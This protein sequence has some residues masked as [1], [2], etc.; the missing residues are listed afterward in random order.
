MSPVALPDGRVP[1]LLSAHAPELLATDATALLRYLTPDARV[2]DIASTLLRTRRIRRHR[3]VV[4]AADSAEL[5]DGLAAVAAGAT[6][7]LVTAAAQV[8]APRLAF[9][10]PGQGGQ[11]PGMGADA[12]HTMPAYRA[13]ADRCA[14]AFESL[15]VASPLPNLL[16]TTGVWS[17]L[18]LQGAQFTHAVALARVWASYGFVADLVLGH[19][20]GE[21]GAAYHAGAITLRTA[22]AVVA[23]R[24]STMELLPDSYAVA[25]LGVSPAEADGL[26]ASVAGWAELSVVNSAS[27]V[28]VSGDRDTV[29]ALVERVA[30]RG[31]FARRLTATSPFHTSVFEPLRDEFVSRLP[32]DE[33][34]EPAVRFVGSATAAG[35]ST[36]TDFAGYWYANLR[37]TVRFDRAA[38]SAIDAGARIFVEMS[39]HPAVHFA[40]NAV[41]DEVLPD[42]AVLTVGSGRRDEPTDDVLSEAVTAVAAADPQFRW[43]ELVDEDRRP[44]RNFPNAPMSAIH[45]WPAPKPLPAAQPELTVATERWVEMA[46]PRRAED[47]RVALLTLGARDDLAD[48]IT[49]CTALSEPELAD[50]LVVVAP[51]VDDD[52][53]R[54][55]AAAIGDGVLDYV[56]AIGTRCRHV[57]L[58]TTGGEQVLSTDPLASPGQAALAA[59]H[60]CLAFEHPDQTFGHLDLPVGD[61][62]TAAATLMLDAFASGTTEVALRGARL[63][64]RE[65][66]GKAAIATPWPTGVLDDVLITGG[67]GVIGMNYARALAERGARRIVL[68]SRRGADPAAV[69]QLRTYG[70]E[71]LSVRCDITDAAQVLSA[72]AE[73]GSGGASLVIHAAGVAGF[74]TRTS[75][76]A[77]HVAQMAA[78]KIGGLATLV[79]C[80]PM[81]D[82]TRIL[83]CSSVSGLWG[84]KGMI[85]Y[86]AANRMLDVM[87]AHLRACGRRCTA[88]RW[89]LWSG[90]SLLGREGTELVERSGLRGMAPASAIGASLGD[91]GIDPLILSADPDRLRIF[92]GAMEPTAAPVTVAGDADPAAAVRGHLA[93][94]L[95]TDPATLDLTMSLFDLGVDSLLAIDLR[96]RLKRTTGQSVPLARLLGGISGTDLVD[97]VVVAAQEKV[98]VSRD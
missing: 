49:R 84:G 52:A 16:R 89:G 74:A 47:R 71:V 11:W 34:D 18:E 22:A 8:S 6:H 46:E 51:T 98:D 1:V 83:L 69:A 26:I 54:G 91:H 10:F 68:L 29:T 5:A 45:L 42:D 88:I 58:V 92:F 23:A 61:L 24:A 73:F 30:A 85:S 66:D 21:I 50:V 14:R 56:D 70:P 65:V 3:V 25:V 55:L 95:S 37:N 2:D 40:L 63:Y 4:R 35:I 64:R 72:A 90:S 15:G 67:A 32:D 93:E 76:S 36:D 62:D 44:L 43:T 27:S 12:Y 82:D 20:L 13:E 59:M 96:K 41:A 39:S 87:A 38:A 60:R 33:F 48:A 19:S 81:R 79:E 75:V 28:A 80:W 7:P 78:A 17:Q 86:S 97:A 57:W 94:V 53:P 9:V 77:D 31:R